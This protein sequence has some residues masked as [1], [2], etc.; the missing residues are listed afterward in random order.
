MFPSAAVLLSQAP[1]FLYAL[2]VTFGL[3]S[4]G[5]WA[6]FGMGGALLLGVLGWAADRRFPRPDPKF[7]FFVAAFL[8]V[9]AL[10]VFWAVNAHAAAIGA[11]KMTS[12]LVPLL[13]LSSPALQARLM[14]KQLDVIKIGFLLCLGLIFCEIKIAEI[15]YRN[16]PDPTFLV[17]KLNRG[18]SYSVL[19]LWPLAAG[20]LGARA[21]K[22]RNLLIGLLAALLLTAFLTTE[23]DATLTGAFLAAAAFLLFRF[24]G[25]LGMVCV[26]GGTLLSLLWPALPILLYGYSPD[27]VIKLPNSWRARVEIWDYMSRRIF[28]NPLLGY[29]MANARFVDISSP[30][31]IY[32]LS[33]HNAYGHPHNAMLQIWGELGFGGLAAVGFLCFLALSGLMK[34]APRLRAYALAAY[35]FAFWLSMTAYNFW[36]DSLWSAFALT[37]L[38]FVYLNQAEIKASLSPKRQ[39]R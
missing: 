14:Q 30:N 36:T 8:L 21:R 10:S 23:S 18:L 5:S 24:S 20:I 7:A 22:N 17:S 26:V 38:A 27:F 9:S 1:F 2:C 13:W 28:E 29:G 19:L 32:Y 12:I 11:L 35:S 15:L 31:R 3:L 16:L 37:A 39:D 4:G 25:V 33:V 34:L 6:V